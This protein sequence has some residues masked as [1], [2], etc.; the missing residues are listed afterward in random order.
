MGEPT[1]RRTRVLL[2]T[3]P[4]WD[5]HSADG[6]VTDLSPESAVAVLAAVL[7]GFPPAPQGGAPRA[8]R[9]LGAAAETPRT[10]P[11]DGVAVAG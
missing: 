2:P 3:D 8:R 1:T 9:P 5:E 11:P 7:E 10:G 4:D 6:I